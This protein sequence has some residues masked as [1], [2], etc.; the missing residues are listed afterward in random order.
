MLIARDMSSKFMKFGFEA[1][2][3]RT[4]AFSVILEIP[5]YDFY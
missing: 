5:I 4:A 2:L 3:E 1:M